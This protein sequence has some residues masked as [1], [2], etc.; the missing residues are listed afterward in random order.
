[1]TRATR[2]ASWAAPEWRSIASRP[3]ASAASWAAARSRSLIGVGATSNGRSNAVSTPRSRSSRVSIPTETLLRVAQLY[4]DDLGF[5]VEVPFTP[6]R[7]DATEEQTETGSFEYLEPEADGFRNYMKADYSV[8]A[9]EMLVDRA[10]LLTLTVP[11]MT[12]LV[13]GMRTLDANW[14]GSDLGVFTDRPGT[15]SNDFFSNLLDMGTVWKKV[16]DE[17]KRF[18]GRDRE[19]G[20][21]KWTGTRVDLIFGSNS[22]L[23]AVAE[24]YASDDATEKFVHDFVAAWD[25]VMMA[26]RFDVK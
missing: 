1:M 23:R 21:V 20:D 22:E 4:R 10:Q 24:V 2:I 17:E 18:E 5:D 14:D 8:S 13:G 19:T 15:L 11:E 6:G 7:T 9:E 3:A 25:K 26:D 12:A 16:S